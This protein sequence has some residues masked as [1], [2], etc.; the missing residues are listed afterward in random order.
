MESDQDCDAALD[1]RCTVQQVD[2]IEPNWRVSFGTGASHRKRQGGH[3]DLISQ[4]ECVAL[5][6]LRHDV[7]MAF[8]SFAL[9]V[10]HVKQHRWILL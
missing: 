8:T 2:V 7:H 9:D 4:Q 6:V 10:C 1:E 5:Y 3:N